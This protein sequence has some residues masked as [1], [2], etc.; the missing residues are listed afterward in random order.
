M[1]MGSSPV[2]SLLFDSSTDFCQKYMSPTSIYGL[3]HRDGHHLFPDEMFVDLFSRLGRNSEPPRV[4]ATVM[5]LQRLEG[6]SDREAVDRLRFDLRWKYAC[7]GLTFDYEGFVHTVLVEMRERLRKSDKPNRIFEAAVH[8]AKDAGLVGRKRVLDS[9]ALYDAVATQDTVTLI[10]SAIRGLLKAAD[11]E[12]EKELRA[13]LKRDDDYRNPGKPVCDWEDVKAR[14]QLVDALARDALALLEVLEDRECTT[15]VR[16]A[17]QLLARVIGQDLEPTPD[18]RFRIARR[19]APDRIIS[20]V[21]PEARHGHK[22]AAR[23]FD[24]YKGH[25]SVDPESEIIVATEVTP[26]NAADGSVAKEL[27][28]EALEDSPEQAPSAPSQSSPLSAQEEPSLP[29]PQGSSP[30]E[31]NESP[32]LRAVHSESSPVVAPIE[33]YGDSSYGTAELLEHL[34]QA[35]AE[36]YVKVQGPSAPAGKFSK[37]HFVIDE[38]TGTVKCPQGKLVQIRRHKDG[39]GLAS[40]GE[41]CKD[42]PLKASCTSGSS[43]RTIQIHPREET[44]SRYRRQQ[45]QEE[46]KRRYRSTRPRV[47]RKLAEVTRRRHGGRRARVRGRERVGQDFALLAAAVNFKRLAALQVRYCD[48]KWVVCKEG[49]GKQGEVAVVVG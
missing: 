2:Q 29:E 33:V 43:G 1:T 14:E 46:W 18:G 19:V 48:T 45:K 37:E 25:I 20:T 4:V 47:E 44:L 39:S 21:D 38:P 9:T 12:L 30:L 36:A 40:F 7:G 32:P 26:G 28:Q 27:L 13:V 10:R 23:G 24:G 15:D 31:Q 34:E 11:A 41:H 3:L 17:V 6:L 16:Q 42:C 35:D 8:V 49:D 5:V 22:T